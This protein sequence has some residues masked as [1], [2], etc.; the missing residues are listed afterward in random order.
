[1]G[2]VWR[3]QTRTDSKDGKK[4]SKYCL[5]HKVAALGWSIKDDH[6]NKYNPESITEIQEKRKKIKNIEGYYDVVRTYGLYGINNKKRLIAVDM[7]LEV[8]KGDYIWMRDNGIYYLGYV[9]DKLR[10]KYNS[11]NKALEHDAANQIKGV[12]WKPIGDE[13]QVPGAVATAFIRGRTIQ[14]I[15][16]SHM[17]EY[18]EYAFWGNPMV[19]ENSNAA[20]LQQ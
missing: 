19:L 6:I 1:M 11:R 16:K 8:E 7:L 20:Y 15:N 3:L 14:R 17:F 9:G 18:A 12:V 10:Y 4:I 5:D 13:S 2:T